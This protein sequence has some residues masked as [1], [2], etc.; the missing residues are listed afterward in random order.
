MVV[1]SREANERGSES[2]C[3]MQNDDHLENQNIDCQA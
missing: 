3:F 1:G 2:A